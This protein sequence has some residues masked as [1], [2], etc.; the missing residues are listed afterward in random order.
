MTF[1]ALV[2]DSV[3]FG[4]FD[5]VDCAFE[6]IAVVD[7]GAENFVVVNVVDA[8]V[9]VGV[10]VVEAEPAIAATDIMGDDRGGLFVPGDVFDV[11]VELFDFVILGAIIDDLF[12]AVVDDDDVVVV[13]GT[14]FTSVSN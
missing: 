12:C 2:F 11:V 6:F 8:V 9:G 5:K 10:G 3:S 1:D 13:V 7:V 14:L 4:G